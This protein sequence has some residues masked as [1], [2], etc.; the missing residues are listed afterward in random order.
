MGNT[1]DFVLFHEINERDFRIVASKRS[2]FHIFLK[3]II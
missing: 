3:R 1:P 2:F